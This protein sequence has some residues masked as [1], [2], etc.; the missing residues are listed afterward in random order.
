MSNNEIELKLKSKIKTESTEEESKSDDEPEVALSENWTSFG[1]PDSPIHKEENFKTF[2][3]MRGS[4][5]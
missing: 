1:L 5:K 2:L 4:K 3:S